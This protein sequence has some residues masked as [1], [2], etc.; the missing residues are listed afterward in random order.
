MTI[1][2]TPT[3]ANDL[4]ACLDAAIKAGGVRTATVAMPLVALIHNTAEKEAKANEE[5]D[6]NLPVVETG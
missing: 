1:E 5:K 3:Q 4:L 2:I 6:Q